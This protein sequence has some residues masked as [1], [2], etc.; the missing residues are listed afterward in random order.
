MSIPPPPV[1]IACR[2]WPSRAVVEPGKVDGG[3]GSPAVEPGQARRRASDGAATRAEP[4]MIGPTGS[5]QSPDRLA[6]VAVRWSLREQQACSTHEI[7]ALWRAGLDRGDADWWRASP[8][9][10]T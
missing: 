10:W 9:P 5:T 3:M 6:Q 8:P 2:C 4:S 7:L 1:R